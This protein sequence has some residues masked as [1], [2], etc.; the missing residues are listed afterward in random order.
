M[1]AVLEA[2]L[3]AVLKSMLGVLFVLQC[4][5]SASLIFTMLSTLEAEPKGVG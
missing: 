4:F 3:E 5:S 2:V 1:L